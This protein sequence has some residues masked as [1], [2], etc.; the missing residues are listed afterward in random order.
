MAVKNEK[1]QSLLEVIFLVPFLFM[2]VALL[3]KIQMAIQMAIVN[4]QYARSQ[5]FVLTANSPE[6]PRL[7]FRTFPKMFSGGNQDRMVLGVADPE[8]LAASE[9]SDGTI[10]PMP[11]TQKINRLGSTVMGSSDRGEVAKRTELR[12]R[13]TAGICTQLNSAGS[14]TPMNEQTIL[15]LGAQRWPFG[16]TVCRYE[17]IL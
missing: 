5:V 7:Q 14:K 9:G 12:I 17:G 10:E 8:S 4:T 15:N 13:N 6:Y 16:T 1:G 11:Q 2:F 3:Y